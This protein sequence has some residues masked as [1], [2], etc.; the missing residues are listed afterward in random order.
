MGRLVLYFKRLVRF[1][2]RGQPVVQVR[3]DIAVR[4]ESELLNG[5]VALVTGGIGGIGLA[6]AKAF[7]DAG[8]TVVIAGRNEDKLV[9]ARQYLAGCGAYGDRIFCS[10]FDVQDCDSFGAVVEAIVSK[11]GG[12]EIDILV[13]N[14]G[15]L[16]GGISSATV[17]EYDNVMN[18]NLRS[19]F[20]L[21]RV[22]ARHLQA[23]GLSG[24]ILNIASSSSIR[25]ADSAYMLSKWGVRAMTQGLAKSFI[26]Y[27]IVVN[28]IAPGPT[29]TSMLGKDSSGD[30]Y[31]PTNPSGR[32]V[33]PEEIAQM[34]TFLVSDMGRMVVGDIVYMTGG[35]GT[36][37]FDDVNYDF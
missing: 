26:R 9:S 18:T 37:T 19:A 14:A 34:A 23:R 21:S 16:G 28:G 3:A 32:Y 11:L 20:F 4:G 30:L 2:L 27:G 36:V 13:N 24:N 29:A 17:Q 31:H 33:V 8:A 12:R 1:V 7:L 10:S 6:V 35:A 5:R 25:P 15:M 22:V